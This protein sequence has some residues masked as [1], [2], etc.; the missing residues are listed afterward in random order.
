MIDPTDWLCADLPPV[1]ACPIWCHR[2]FHAWNPDGLGFRRTHTSH[3]L[4]SP[5]AGYRLE[6]HQVDCWASGE[7]EIGKPAVVVDHGGLL[8]DD[9]A[10]LLVSDLTLV[11]ASL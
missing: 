1:I 3:D 7:V 9:E 10:A 5:G 8:D 4:A 11:A 6:L 2:E